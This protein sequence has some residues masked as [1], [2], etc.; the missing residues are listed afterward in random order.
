MTTTFK[1]SMLSNRKGSRRITWTS[2]QGVKLEIRE[3]EEVTPS[4]DSVMSISHSLP[5]PNGPTG[6]FAS[7]R[8]DA[9]QLFE[10]AEAILEWYGFKA[11]PGPDHQDY[12]LSRHG[13]AAK[14]I[15]EWL[16]LSAQAFRAEAKLRYDR[17]GETQ[18]RLALELEAKADDYEEL[19]VKIDDGEW[20]PR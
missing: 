16:R 19:A 1:H 5:A 20:Q 6:V 9:K 14:A 13:S 3:S 17:S 12:A 8:F 15:A 10:F 18:A 2:P 4:E 7:V 11:Y